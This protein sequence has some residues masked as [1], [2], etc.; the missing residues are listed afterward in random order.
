MVWRQVDGNNERGG[1]SMDVCV[2]TS[3]HVMT[4]LLISKY[5]GWRGG[6]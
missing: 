1:G 5:K 6:E 3:D 2:P 4:Y